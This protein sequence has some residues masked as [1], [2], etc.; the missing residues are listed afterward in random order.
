MISWLLQWRGV[1]WEDIKPYLYV[2]KNTAVVKHLLRVASGVDSMV[3]GEPQ[4]FGQIKQAFSTAQSEG[5][6]GKHL[7]QL[8]QYTFAST[9]QI[10]TQT[11]IGQHPVSFAYFCIGQTDF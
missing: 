7:H 3:V 8:F 11:A 9:K 1:S 4:I 2:H 10:R 6:L 5:T